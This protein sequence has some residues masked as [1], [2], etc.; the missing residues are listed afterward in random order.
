MDVS[1]VSLMEILKDFVRRTRSQ[2]D[3]DKIDADT[4]LLQGGYVDSFGL[5]ALIAEIE[6]KLGLSFDDSAF[7]P[8]D[9]ESPR[10]L[11]GRIRD[12]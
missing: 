7:L 10:T 12:L 4:P 6:E 1:F 9:F 11:A 5:V 3:A 8:E 2:S